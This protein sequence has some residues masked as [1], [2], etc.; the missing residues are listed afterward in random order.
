[1]KGPG[2]M[3]RKNRDRGEENLGRKIF[4]RVSVNPSAVRDRTPSG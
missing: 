1:M 3:T 2:F 4:D